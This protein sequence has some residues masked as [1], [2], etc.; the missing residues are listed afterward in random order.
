MFRDW[1]MNNLNLVS[2]LI[3][4]L[5]LL[6]ICDL[7]RFIAFRSWRMFSSREH[8]TLHASTI[9]NTTSTPRQLCITPNN[10]LTTNT[11]TTNTNTTTPSTPNE[12]PFHIYHSP[13]ADSNVQDNRRRF[14]GNHHPSPSAYIYNPIFYPVSNWNESPL[15]HSNCCQHDFLKFTAPYFVYVTKLCMECTAQFYW[16]LRSFI[17]SFVRSLSVMPVNQSVIQS[18]IESFSQPVIQSVNQSVSHWVI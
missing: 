12:P 16:F 15:A 9:C 14:L 18:V 8:S 1:D 4:N 5:L 2:D 6:L 17:R 7:S 13:T 3:R 11:L 10:T